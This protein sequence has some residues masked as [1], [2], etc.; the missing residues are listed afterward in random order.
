M[1]RVTDPDLVSSLDEDIAARG[2]TLGEFART[3]GVS[4]D[5]LLR[6][7]QGTGVRPAALRRIRE[8]RDRLPVVASPVMEASA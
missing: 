8:A 1:A 4:D 3:A 2:L 6:F 7:R 5:T